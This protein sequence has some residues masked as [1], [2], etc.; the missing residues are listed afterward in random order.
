MG[1][2]STAWDRR[3]DRIH[4]SSLFVFF[5]MCQKKMKRHVCV[6]MQQQREMHCEHMAVSQCESWLNMVI[7]II[8][9]CWRS[10]VFA[11]LVLYVNLVTMTEPIGFPS[12]FSKKKKSSPWCNMSQ[13]IL[14]GFIHVDSCR[15]VSQL[16]GP[17]LLLRRFTMKFGK[18]KTSPPDE[19]WQNLT[20]LTP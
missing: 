12:S 17:Q 8:I 18:D 5:T 14:N 19:W 4:V 10:S 15:G 6:W 16:V 2:I 20:M 7:I 13:I 3:E 1:Q 11:G 9:V